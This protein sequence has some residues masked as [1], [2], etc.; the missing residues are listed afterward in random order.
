MGVSPN[1]LRKCCSK[2]WVEV[3]IFAWFFVSWNFDWFVHLL[4]STYTAT[5]SAI[6][7]TLK[8]RSIFSSS[9]K[10]S[11]IFLD[12]WSTKMDN[13]LDLNACSDWQISYNARL[14]FGK[15]IPRSVPREARK[16]HGVSRGTQRQMWH[17][18]FPYLFHC[19]T[20][21]YDRVQSLGAKNHWNYFLCSERQ[22]VEKSM[23]LSWRSS[24]ENSKWWRNQV[25]PKE[26]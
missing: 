17:V 24:A 15:W 3:K 25:E 16:K 12:I 10:L 14:P 18:T 4:Y 19:W 21:M 1:I 11:G 7:N 20:V 8:V 5:R 22:I 13:R 6:F 26:V 9:V 23:S 2:C